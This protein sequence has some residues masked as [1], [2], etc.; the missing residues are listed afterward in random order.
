MKGELKVLTAESTSGGVISL[1]N[2]MKGELKVRDFSRALSEVEGLE[3]HEGRI[4][5]D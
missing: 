3:S 1:T 2:L 4:E 5:R